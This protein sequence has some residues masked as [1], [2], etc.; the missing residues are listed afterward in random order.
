MDAP[1]QAMV[2]PKKLKVVELRAELRRRGLAADGLKAV[3]VDRLLKGK[4]GE[5]EEQQDASA[6]A[7]AQERARDTAAVQRAIGHGSDQLLVSELPTETPWPA[8]AAGT[9]RRRK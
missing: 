9:T 4:R 1:T 8:A 5:G 2:E 3:L 6:Q 7:Q